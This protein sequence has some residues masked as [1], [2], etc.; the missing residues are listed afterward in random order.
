MSMCCVFP[1]GVSLTSQR[2]NEAPK[3]QHLG[4]VPIGGA[5]ERRRDDVDASVNVG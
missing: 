3:L 2:V 5:T 1:R 4:G